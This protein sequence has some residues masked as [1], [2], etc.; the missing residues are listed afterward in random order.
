[1]LHASPWPNC[2]CMAPDG[3]I[4]TPDAWLPRQDPRMLVGVLV[5]GLHLSPLP[6]PHTSPPR[7]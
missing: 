5:W 1:M 7:E 2:C 3:F 4:R 6:P